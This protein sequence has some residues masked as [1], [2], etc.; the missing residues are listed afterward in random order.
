MFDL[1]FSLICYSFGYF[2]GKYEEDIFDFFTGKG[3]K[4]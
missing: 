3:G 4:M 1:I 2:L